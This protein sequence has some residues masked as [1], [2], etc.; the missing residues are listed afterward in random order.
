MA[1]QAKPLRDRWAN[2]DFPVLVEV[3]RRIDEGVSA[4]LDRDIAESIPMPVE[5]VQLAI[6]A[7]ERRGFVESMATFDG[8]MEVV[9]VA[10]QASLLTGLYPD[11]EDVTERLASVF[12]Q[13]AERTSDPEEKGAA[14]QGGECAGRP[15][16]RGGRRGRGRGRLRQQL[17]AGA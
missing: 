6:S 7:L 16:W 17:P 4:V 9:E 2:R 5:E 11:G 10:G 8:A 3:T 12:R 14:A 1:W 15:R 13:A